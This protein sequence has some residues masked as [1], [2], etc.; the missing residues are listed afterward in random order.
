MLVVLIMPL[1]MSTEAAEFERVG[2]AVEAREAVMDYETLASIANM[3][4]PHQ[5]E[6][7]LALIEVKEAIAVPVH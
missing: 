4:F 7:C 2:Q 1:M 6:E 3:C 5:E